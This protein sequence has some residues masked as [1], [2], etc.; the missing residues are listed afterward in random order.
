LYALFFN[1]LF[2]SV[3]AKSGFLNIEKPKSLTLSGFVRDAKI[4]ESISGAFIYQKEKPDRAV[5]TNSYG[6]FSISLP[7]GTYD[8]VIQFLGYKDKIISVD[9]KEDLTIIVDL[10]E[11]IISLSEVIVTGKKTTS[12]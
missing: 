9:L 8:I 11:E 4:G 1:V 10:E 6:Y 2:T 7:T 5:T 12:T 3:S